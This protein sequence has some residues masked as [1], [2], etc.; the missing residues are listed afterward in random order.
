[1]QVRAIHND[2]TFINNNRQYQLISMLTY[3]QHTL[4]S[5][6]LKD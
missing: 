1:M 2:Y 6:K 4:L 5:E 3:I